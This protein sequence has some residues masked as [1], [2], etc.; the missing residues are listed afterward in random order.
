MPTVLRADGFRVVI[1]LPPREHPPPHVHVR[2]ADGEAVILLGTSGAAPSLREVA[3]MRTPDVVR[4]FRLVE[5]HGEY[6]MEC[7]RSHHG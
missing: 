3:G 2:N 1:F 5:A 4:A 6:L 7:W